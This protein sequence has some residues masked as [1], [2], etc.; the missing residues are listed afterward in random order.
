MHSPTALNADQWRSAAAE[1]YVRDL[2]RVRIKVPACLL[3]S[4]TLLDSL[5]T[6]FR[7]RRVQR[8]R[9][10]ND[11]KHRSGT[12]MSFSRELK[13]EQSG[14][15]VVTESGGGA[16]WSALCA[17]PLFSSELSGSLFFISGPGFLLQG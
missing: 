10:G 9:Q 15:C 4:S 7:R 5:V 12:S 2:S 11:E 1:P 6:H 13:V 8:T 16:V 3:Y 14:C 17:M